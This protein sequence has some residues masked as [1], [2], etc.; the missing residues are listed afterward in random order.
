MS[1]H[2]ICAYNDSA[3]LLDLT[4]TAA[5]APDNNIDVGLFTELSLKVALL[6]LHAGGRYGRVGGYG[7]CGRRGR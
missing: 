5:S 4:R 1:H 3:V 7:G 6:A 2:T